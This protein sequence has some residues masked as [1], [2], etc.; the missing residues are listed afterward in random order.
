MIKLIT[1]HNLKDPS[2]KQGRS[3]KEINLGK[4]HKIPL[5]MLVE[6]DGGVR[7]FVVKHTRDCDGTPLYSLCHD[8]EDTEQE[9]E[10]FGN[11]GWVN[12]FNEDSL[13]VINK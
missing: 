7:L 8:K 9:R 12:G 3:Y 10:G 1:I 2:D 11:F 6:L 4:N 5:G 13:I